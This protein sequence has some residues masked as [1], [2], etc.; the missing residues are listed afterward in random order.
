M[1]GL[2]ASPARWTVRGLDLDGIT[3]KAGF[4]DRC[5]SALELPEWFG[6]NWDAL[7]DALSDPGQLPETDPDGALV[8]VV[9][10]WQ[11]FKERGPGQW[12]IACEVFAQASAAKVLLALG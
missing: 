9:S 4:M 10:G 6:R 7:A 12:E 11:E 5:A 8:L 2:P 3:D 1:S